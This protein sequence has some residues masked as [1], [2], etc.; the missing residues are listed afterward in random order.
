MAD[1]TQINRRNLPRNTRANGV[2]TRRRILD[3]A[4]ALFASQGY[5]ATS[6]RQISGAS[7]VDIATLKYHFGDKATLFAGVYQHGHQEFLARLNPLLNTMTR[8]STTLEVKA[9]IRDLVAVAHDSL[10]LQNDFVRMVLFRILEDSSDIHHLENELQGIALGL[11]DEGF[12]GM[13]RRG[14][15]RD[16]DVRALLALL[17]TA[18]P[19]WYVTSEVKPTWLGSPPPLSDQGRERAE[20]FLCQLL[21]G[22]LLP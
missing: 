10:S 14:L 21:E 7:S 20:R 15:I 16:V 8:I 22:Y 13:I 9:L 6:L 5:E 1:N 19:M 3:E 11:L 17:I 18:I 4:T 2:A 12:R